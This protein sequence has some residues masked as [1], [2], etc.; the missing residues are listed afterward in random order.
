MNPSDYAIEI[1]KK[2]GDTLTSDGTAIKDLDE[3]EL[4]RRMVTRYPAERAKIQGLD[5]YLDAN[6]SPEEKK[7][8][9]PKT[10]LMQRLDNVVSLFK[11]RSANVAAH[12][13]ATEEK[14]QSLASGLFQ[15]GGEAAGF[16]GDLGFEALKAITPDAIKQPIKE[17]AGAVA[18]TEEVQGVMADYEKW[19]A[20][21]PELAENL[22]AAVNIASLIPGIGI[23][24]KGAQMAL[25]TGTKIAKEGA[26]MVAETAPKVSTAIAERLAPNLAKEAMDAVV[27][28]PVGKKATIRSLEKSGQPGGYSPD[29]SFI[30][31]LTGAD[32]YVPTPRDTQVAQAVA[33][34]VRKSNPPSKNI[35]NINNKISEVSETV[36]RPLLKANPAPFNTGT[37]ANRLKAVE[38]PDFIKADTTLANTYEM[39]RNRFI[40][41]VR[42]GV[43]TKEGLWEARKDIDDI[44]EQQFGA[45]GFNPEKYSALQK[46]ILDMRRAT[47]DFI[48]EGIPDDGF[49]K[50]MQTL[51]RM[52]EARHNLALDNYAIQN[53][54]SW[55]KWIA[56][57][58]KKYAALK[59]GALAGTIGGGFMLLTPD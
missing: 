16:V 48:A 3:K 56:N 10:Q 54:D 38:I 14:K 52:Y 30:G 4:I 39:V 12:R 2:W 22:E 27:I 32:K 28:G 18:G 31:K 46:A 35:A 33:G 25:K 7:T 45:A 17:A 19:K 5:E 15:S 24:A 49:K 47:N 43:K 8:I 11:D 36:V 1:K 51:S 6:L 9:P 29:E 26:E 13:K 34:L 23:P 37:Y 50:Q 55:Q 44:I 21:N 20:E 40:E 53:K 59:A 42:K 41:V 58:P 57:N